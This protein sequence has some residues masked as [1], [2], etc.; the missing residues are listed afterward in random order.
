[1]EKNIFSDLFRWLLDRNSDL[2]KCQSSVGPLL[3]QQMRTDSI[4]IDSIHDKSNNFSTCTR[5]AW[6]ACFVEL[7]VL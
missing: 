1:M 7:S 4:A 6:D 3:M 2:L 5:Y